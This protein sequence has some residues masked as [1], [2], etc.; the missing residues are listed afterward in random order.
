M[1]AEY[2]HMSTGS[3]NIPP[4]SALNGSGGPT[5]PSGGMGRFEGPRSPPGRQSERTNCGG[6]AGISC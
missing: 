5:T 4:A 2:R 6:T 3:L 1:P